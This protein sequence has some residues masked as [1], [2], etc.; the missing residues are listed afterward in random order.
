MPDN[1]DIVHELRR[2]VRV[3]AIIA[4]KEEKQTDQISTLSNMGFQ[5][6]EIA[7][8]VSTT[9]N[10]VRVTLAGIRKKQDGRRK[11][12]KNTRNDK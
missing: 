11:S 7:E 10:T 5:P 8:I 4:T 12:T 3:L 2:I 9:P 6:K 1:A